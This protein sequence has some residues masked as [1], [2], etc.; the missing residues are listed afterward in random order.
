MTACSQQRVPHPSDPSPQGRGSRNENGA[1][2]CTPVRLEVL[3][4]VH[5]DERARLGSHFS[6][7]P[8]RVCREDDWERAI[9]LAWTLRGNEFNI[10]WSDVLIASI[11]IYD[12][13]R[14][15]TID[16]HFHNV[17]QLA[18]LL[19]HRPGYGGNYNE[20]DGLASFPETNL[21]S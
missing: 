20:A 7:I 9:V 4:G 18:P 2:W 6:V 3:G 19:L 12:K 17:A 15:Y 8:D 5:R 11:A 1:Q 21:D 16:K 14:L 10:P 13:V